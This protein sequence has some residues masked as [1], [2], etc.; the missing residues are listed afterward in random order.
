MTTWMRTLSCAVLVATLAWFGGCRDHADDAQESVQAGHPRAY[1]P[2]HAQDDAVSCEGVTHW[3]AAF[4]S[5]GEGEL[6]RNLGSLF[7]CKPGASAPWCRQEPYEPGTDKYYPPPEWWREAW[8]LKGTCG[9]EGS[10]GNRLT[11]RMPPAPPGA[12]DP[13]DDPPLK[14]VLRCPLEPGNELPL[15]ATWGEEL[16]IDRLPPCHYE[17]IVNAPDG[18]RPLKTPAIVSITEAK[19]QQVYYD[20]EFGP[21][22]PIDKL[23]ALPGIKLEVFAYGLSQPRQMA[24]GNDVLYVGSS[25][26]PQYVGSYGDIAGFVYALPLDPATHKP[27]GELHIVASDQIEPHGV[28]Y[29]KGTLYFSTT[30]MLYRLDNADTTF[31]NPHPAIVFPFPA[32]AQK[33]PLPQTRAVSDYRRWHQKHPLYFDPTRPDDDVLYTA[34]GI[35]CNICYMQPFDEHY[36]ALLRYDLS[37]GAATIL[38]TGIRNSVGMDWNPATHELWFTDNNR[39]TTG[40]DPATAVAY[41]DEVNRLSP[42]AKPYGA[43]FMFGKRTVGYTDREFTCSNNPSDECK[44]TDP[45]GPTG[46]LP[47]VP[48]GDINPR[49]INENNY[50]PAALELKPGAAPLGLKFITAATYPGTGTAPGQDMLFAAHGAGSD[51]DGSPNIRLAHVQANAIVSVWPL[52]MGWRQPEGLIGRPTDFLTLADGSLLISDDV[53]N[54]IF[55]LSYDPTNLPDTALILLMGPPPANDPATTS[56]MPSGALVNADGTRWPFQLGWSGSTRLNGLSPGT[57]RV[58]MDDVGQFTPVEPVISI[59]IKTGPAQPIVLAYHEPPPVAA[60]LTIKAPPRP[61]GEGVKNDME[62]TLITGGQPR[63]IHVPWGGE[64]VETLG[65]GTHEL[66]YPYMPKAI[67]VPSRHTVRI[68]DNAAQTAAPA[69]EV[70]ESIGKTMLGNAPGATPASGGCARCHTDGLGGNPGIAMGWAREGREALHN[71]VLSM[72]RNV[73]GGHCDATCAT[74]ITTYLFDDLWKEYLVPAESFGVR[75]LRKLTRVEYARSVHDLTEV[76]VN[77]DYLPPDDPRKEYVYPGEASTGIFDETQVRAYYEQALAIG[78]AADPAKLGYTGGDPATFVRLFGHRVFRRPLTEAEVTRY[79]ALME[80][81]DDGLEPVARLVAALLSSPNF[82]YR[83][84]LGEPEPGK[85]DVYKLTGDELATALS[86]GYLG[87]TPSPELL[88]EAEAGRL[89]TPEGVRA[90][91]DAMLATD[92]GKNQ[93]LQFIRYYTRTTLPPAEKDGLPAAVAADMWEE[94]ALFVK[95]VIGEA[96]GTVAMLFNPGFTYLNQALA[97]HY[98]IAGVSGSTFRRV[99]LTGD[100]RGRWGGLLHE[101]AFLASRAA[102]DALTTSMIRRGFAVRENMLCRKFG[103]QENDGKPVTYPERPVT[104]RE[105]WNLRTKGNGEFVQ[106]CWACHQYVND[107]GASMEHYDQTGRYRLKEHAIN[108]GYTDQLVDIDSRA[109][110]VSNGGSLTWINASD[111]RDITMYLP[112]ENTATQCLA[113]SYYRY[114]YGDEPGL[115][116]AKLVN[117]VTQALN[118]SGNLRDMLKQLGSADALRYRKDPA[119]NDARIGPVTARDTVGPAKLHWNDRSPS[120]SRAPTQGAQP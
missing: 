19:G 69:Y 62:V 92:A 78:K 51:N 85:P 70:V 65:Y 64:V 13:G 66:V 3:K 29:H 55:R 43:P 52:A 105:H 83:S 56:A 112:K 111:V 107:I 119:A 6:V 20:L 101:G 76:E 57:Y 95:D 34:V 88:A 86:F 96:N 108:P 61:E 27:N 18:F 16:T 31:R 99:A 35:P 47:G 94:Q 72:S 10:D 97:E 15:K 98:G 39:Q 1:P 114:V 54:V 80:P 115:N 104:T 90:A 82:L 33:F 46:A 118:T 21:P 40:Q 75:Q 37:T 42:A 41:P 79:A 67:P 113:D 17:L 84:E 53:A 28:A 68:V 49:L 87:T 63:S 81:L 110:L 26:I 11:L 36:G 102:S 8:A 4:G 30:G 25:A 91:I 60:P 74:E 14:G 23:T 89:D 5:I 12:P 116:G 7:E 45:N 93:F 109:P 48:I 9:V 2:R 73:D 58:E 100:D 59:E 77:A 106:T 44:K 22:F 71:K 32:D 50:Q 117:E 120:S 103:A 24:M 38:A